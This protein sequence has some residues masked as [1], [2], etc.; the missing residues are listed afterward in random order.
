MRHDM[1]KRFTEQHSGGGG[2]KF[3]R[4]HKENVLADEDGLM[5]PVK[6]MSKIHKVSRKSGTKYG[7]GADYAIMRRFLMS[8]LGKPWDEVYSEICAEADARSFDGHYLRENLG[9][10]VEH[11]VYIGEDG[12]I[13]NKRHFRVGSW[14]GQF[15]VDPEDKTLKMVKYNRRSSRELPKTVF[16][17]D[18]Q[19]YHKD[20]GAWF[21]VTMK[22]VPMTRGVHGYEHYTTAPVYWSDAFNAH[23]DSTKARPGGY[24][25]WNQIEAVRNKYGVSQNGKPWY[26][27]EKQS[28]N[29]KE[30]KRLKQKYDL[31]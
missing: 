10:M 31:S 4:H 12:E 6:G 27:V 21:R 7:P 5:V 24:Y 13:Y 3:P 30:I 22:E 28:A 20:H 25:Y 14:R 9:Y 2:S 23:V 11:D 16:E 26:C 18:G 8:R 15:Y 1:K 17:M 29:S 19:L